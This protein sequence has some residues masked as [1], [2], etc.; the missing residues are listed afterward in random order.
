LQGLGSY[1]ATS[2]AQ[3]G[4]KLICWLPLAVGILGQWKM[5]PAA[6]PFP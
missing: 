3:G 5:H 1:A 2:E 4:E 6:A